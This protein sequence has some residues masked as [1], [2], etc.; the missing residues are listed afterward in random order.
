[1]LA[2]H[3]LRR[4]RGRDHLHSPDPRYQEKVS[5]LATVKARVTAAGDAAYPGRRLF[6]V[7]DTW[8]VHYHPVVLAALEPQASPFPFFTP[9]SRPTAPSPRATRLNLPS[10]LV[11]LP[12]PAPW[13]N[14]SEKRWRWR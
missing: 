5:Y 10:R 7:L 13:L 4:K 14:P 1:V 9:P 3:R 2:K 12:T 11:P 6:L 8:P